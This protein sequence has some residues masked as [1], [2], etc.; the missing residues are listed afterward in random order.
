MPTVQQENC[1]Y[2]WKIGTAIWRGLNLHVFLVDG[3]NAIRE[4][5]NV[6]NVIRDLGPSCPYFWTC[7][8]TYCFLSLRAAIFSSSSNIN[9]IAVNCLL[10]NEWGCLFDGNSPGLL[11]CA[12]LE[13]D[14]TRR[15]VWT[16]HSDGTKKERWRNGNVTHSANYPYCKIPFANT[17]PSNVH[18]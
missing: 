12:V 11:S 15:T 10:E 3:T 7:E 16:D 17:E 2:N 18:E 13:G 6:P 14:W 9:A 5:P 1:F 8:P 4:V